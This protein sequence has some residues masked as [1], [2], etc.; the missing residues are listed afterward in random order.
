MVNFCR[1][2]IHNT[3]KQNSFLKTS[4]RLSEDQRKVCEKWCSDRKRENLNESRTMNGLAI[5][6]K[7]L[8]LHFEKPK[9]FVLTDEYDSPIMKA[10]FNSKMDPEELSGILKFY[11][12]V[13]ASL[14]KDNIHVLGAVV[15]GI[16]V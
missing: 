15:T 13:L 7:Y 9:F 6:C 4:P 2:I 1:V 3:F 8:C 12:D 11:I 16:E 14:L 10:V 5:L